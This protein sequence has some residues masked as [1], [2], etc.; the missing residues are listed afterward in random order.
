VTGLGA[1]GI[2]KEFFFVLLVQLAIVIF[3]I[4]AQL[5]QLGG[6]K[7][8]AG[9]PGEAQPFPIARALSLNLPISLNLSLSHSL[10]LSLSHSLTR[11]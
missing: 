11:V 4:L 6:F 5:L 2:K 8:A 7:V 9:W 1:L 3:V 10:T